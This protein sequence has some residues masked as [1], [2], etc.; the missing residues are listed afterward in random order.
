MTAKAEA[1]KEVLEKVNERLA[2]HPFTSNST[3]YSDGMYDCLEW[4]DSEIE[5]LEK[6]L[7]GED[8]G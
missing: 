3:E 6:E 5:E 1:Y 7:V 4:V 2:V 8:N